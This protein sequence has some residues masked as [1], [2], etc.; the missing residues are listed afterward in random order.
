MFVFERVYFDLRIKIVLAFHTWF[1]C[2]VCSVRLHSVELFSSPHTDE[3]RA[4]PTV[5]AF[6]IF[7]YVHIHPVYKSYNWG[8]QCSFGLNFVQLSLSCRASII[9]TFSFLNVVSASNW[10]VFPL[11]LW[12]GAERKVLSAVAELILRSGSEVFQWPCKANSAHFPTP[13]SGLSSERKDEESGYN[14]SHPESRT[15]GC[16]ALQHSYSCR[17]CGHLYL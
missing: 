5:H 14:C 15:K 13:V 17:V 7:L 8:W 6:R 16:S 2:P 1:S 12:E 3:A 4:T 9:W 11:R 10:V